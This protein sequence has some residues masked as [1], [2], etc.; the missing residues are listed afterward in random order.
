VTICAVLSTLDA[1][2]AAVVPILLPVLACLSKN[3]RSVGRKW[4]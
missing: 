4:K 3:S 2:P 1:A